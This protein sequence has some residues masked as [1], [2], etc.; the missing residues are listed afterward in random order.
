MATLGH[1]P[2]LL[3]G[4]R[5]PV[6]QQTLAGRVVEPEEVPAARYLHEIRA[7]A[8]GLQHPGEAIGIGERAVLV[9]GRLD[10]EHRRQTAG[11]VTH[12]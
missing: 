7:V 11:Y 5:D 4:A 9:I 1:P 12:G 3:Q 6:T 10:D 8:R 2:P